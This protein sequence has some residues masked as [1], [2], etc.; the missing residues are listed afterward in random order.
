MPF[1]KTSGAGDTS[2]FHLMDDK[3][4]YTGECDGRTL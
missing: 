3:N 4:F 2:T 1:G